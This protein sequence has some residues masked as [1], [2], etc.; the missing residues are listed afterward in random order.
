MKGQQ[1]VM[2]LDRIYLNDS[3][4]IYEGF[5]VEQAPAIY[6]KILRKIEQDTL[7]LSMKDIWK[8]TREYPRADTTTVTAPSK[9]AAHRQTKNKYVYAEALGSAGLYSLNY[10]FRFNENRRDGWG[11]RS[12][13][14]YLNLTTYNYSGDVLNYRVLLLP[15]Q[16][17]YLFGKQKRFFEV[18]LGATYIIKSRQGTL[19]A[20]EYEYTIKY[21]GRRIPNVLG[22]MSLGYRR[23]PVKGKIM[24]GISAT[25]LIGNSFTLPNIGF[26]IGYK[27]S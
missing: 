9:K 25:P 20:P 26:K 2:P 21:L 27:L 18:G 4:T 15:L 22:T 8:M 1:V 12:G 19:M 13:F 11:L 3:I 14:S 23:L 5:I 7:Q 17:N 10:D 24:W 16:V 6:V